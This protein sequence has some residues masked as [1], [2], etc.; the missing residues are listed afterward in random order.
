MPKGNPCV[1]MTVVVVFT[2][3]FLLFVEVDVNVGGGRVMGVPVTA[4]VGKD[5]WA[6]K[7]LLIERGGQG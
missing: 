5:V 1:G 2:S 4:Y 7:V 3:P 6:E